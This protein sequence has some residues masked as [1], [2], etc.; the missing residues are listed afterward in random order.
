MAHHDFIDQAAAAIKGGADTATLISRGL[1]SGLD[2]ET[3]D[4]LLETAQDLAAE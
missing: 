4:S 2:L 1:W 3:I